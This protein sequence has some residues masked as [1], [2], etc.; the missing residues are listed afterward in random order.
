MGHGR[1]AG[2]GGFVAE[3]HDRMV[4]ILPE[5]AHATWLNPRTSLDSVRSLMERY[6]AARM[7][8]VWRASPAAGYARK[9]GADCGGRRLSHAA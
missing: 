7:H 8:V 3:I 6:P 9:E 2:R 1:R 5:E 4:V